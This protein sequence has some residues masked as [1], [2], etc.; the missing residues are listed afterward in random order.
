MIF[1]RMVTF[2]LAWAVFGWVAAFSVEAGQL[3]SGLTPNQA[4]R[5]ER[6]VVRSDFADYNLAQNGLESRESGG[7]IS[8]SPE[9][10][11]PPRAP[12]F[13][14]NTVHQ[15]LGMGSIG[16]ALAAAATV[17]ED[18]LRGNDSVHHQFA[19]AAAALGVGAIMSGFAVHGEDVFNFGVGD[20]DNIHMTLGILGTMGY[21]AAVN[22]APT[23]AHAAAGMLGVAAMTLTIAV[24]W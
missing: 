10:V 23:E 7:A 24:T 11:E 19:V 14:Q 16:V 13:T 12:W 1:R 21:L 4:R 5:A 6:S 8:K 20:P 15:F 17:P 9:Q 18:E 2:S 3:D 22:A